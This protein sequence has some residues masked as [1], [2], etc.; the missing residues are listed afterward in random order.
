MLHLQCHFGMDRLD[1][2]R[3]GAK[4]TGVDLSD[5]AIKEA[6]ELDDELKL[7]QRLSAAMF[8]T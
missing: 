1:W 7:T 6:R 4:V 2:G 5:E 3:A 8:M